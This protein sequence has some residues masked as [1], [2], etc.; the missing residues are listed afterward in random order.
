MVLE[1]YSYP[2]NKNAFK[3]LIAAEYVGADVAVPDFKMGVDNKKPDF[4]RLN[5]FG[6][7]Y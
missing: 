3:A 2:H 1:I 6:K 7:V 4:L 5:P